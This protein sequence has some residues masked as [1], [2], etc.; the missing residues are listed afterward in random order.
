M[1]LTQVEEERLSEGQRLEEQRQH[2]LL[3]IKVRRIHI[4]LQ[5][6]MLPINIITSSHILR[7]IC[8]EGQLKSIRNEASLRRCFFHTYF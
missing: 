1:V 5:H 4:Q 6:Q 7:V 3:E 2:G 8:G